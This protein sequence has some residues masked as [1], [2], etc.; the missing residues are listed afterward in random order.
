[1]AELQRTAAA[2]TSSRRES[3]RLVDCGHG[4]QGVDVDEDGGRD[5][6]LLFLRQSLGWLFKGS[7]DVWDAPEK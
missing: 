3:F 4:G 7:Q 6:P 1:M 5:L 2:P